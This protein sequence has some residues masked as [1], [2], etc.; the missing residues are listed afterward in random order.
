MMK[1]DVSS[2]IN[3]DL[4]RKSLN[5]YTKK[6]FRM[7][8]KLENPHILDIG[9]G[10]GVPT[11]ELAR[12]SKGRIMGIDID[13]VSLDK[14]NEKIEEVGLADRVKT[15]KCSMS[16]IKFT[17]ESFDVIW[18]E[19]AIFAIGF[20]KGLKEWRRLIKSNGFLVVHDEIGDIQKK[21]EL[22]A[23]CGYK[24]INYF[25]VSGDI[26]WDEYYCPLEKQIQK[27]RLEYQNDINAI[28]ILDKEQQEVDEF[29]KNPKLNGSVF[30]VMVKC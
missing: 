29:K 21:L 15:V 7:L 16:N 9:C 1:K 22:I 12:L 11:L 13:Q 24:L 20:G 18:T 3:H 26:W 4:L 5:K 19:G 27:L 2:A 6:A 14:L 28:S 30:F 23:I 10:T 25:I 8:P 17:D